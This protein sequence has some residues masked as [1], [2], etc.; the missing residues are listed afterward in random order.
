MLSL[1]SGNTFDAKNWSD[2]KTEAP[3]LPEVSSIQKCPHCG[4]Y[5][6]SYKQGLKISKDSYSLELGTLTFKESVEALE[7][8][9]IEGL[10]SEDEILVRI[11]LVYAYND[12][13]YRHPSDLNSGPTEKDMLIFKDNALKLIGLLKKEEDLTF[14]A[15]L[16]REVSDFANCE[17]IL[18]EAKR[19]TAYEMSVRSEI[20]R[21]C[22]DSDAN[23]FC[24]NPI[25]DFDSGTNDKSDDETK[26]TKEGGNNGIGLLPWIIISCIGILLVVWLFWKFIC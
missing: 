19:T 6:L 21:H 3:M 16:Y 26:E 24:L 18:R 9:L 5:Y 7:Q 20:L 1:L 13:F 8:L 25:V 15:E 11:D 2:S 12:N 23:V 22:K 10:D 14:K 4:K 17:K